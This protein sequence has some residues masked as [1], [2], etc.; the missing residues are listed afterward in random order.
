MPSGIIQPDGTTAEVRISDDYV[1]KV[2][3]AALKVQ[4]AHDVE[5]TWASL[6]DDRRTAM[7][8][9]TANVLRALTSLGWTLVP[10]GR[11]V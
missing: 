1:L 9:G 2:C 10:P 3:L 4:G 7:L 6:G 11:V 5:G 8:H